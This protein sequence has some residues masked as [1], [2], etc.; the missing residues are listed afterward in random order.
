MLR[1]FLPELTVRP[2]LLFVS[3]LKR[4]EAISH[5]DNI[6]LVNNRDISGY[7]VACL[8]RVNLY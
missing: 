7:S 1:K 6:K 5:R 3:L 4:V 8:Y 2:L